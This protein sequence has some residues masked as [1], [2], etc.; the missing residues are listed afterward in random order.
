MFYIHPRAHLP[1]RAA[2]VLSPSLVVGAIP[3]KAIFKLST[4]LSV[5]VTLKAALTMAM[6]SSLLFACL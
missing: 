3:P 6:S 4:L 1:R 5:T 2:A